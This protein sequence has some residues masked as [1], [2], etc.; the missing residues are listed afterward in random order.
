MKNSSLIKIFCIMIMLFSAISPTI[1]QDEKKPEAKKEKLPFD[2][3]GLGVSMSSSEQYGA[4]LIYAIDYTLHVGLKLGVYYDTGN[5]KDIQASTMVAF[6]PF[7]KYFLAANRSFKPFIMGAFSFKSQT[8]SKQSFSSTEI[9]TYQKTTT[10]LSASVGAEWFPISS[11]GI[12]GGVKGLELL[13][14]PTELRIGTYE[15]F[16]GVEWFIDF[17]VR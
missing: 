17:G 5:D 7:A 6:T 4:H 16:L 9:E 11:F 8:V 1:A 14:D 12:F 3:V 15:T 2:D 10:S 13:F